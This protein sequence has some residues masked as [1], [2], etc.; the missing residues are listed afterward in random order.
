MS[1]LAIIAA[2]EALEDYASL[3]WVEDEAA[4]ERI[5]RF[6]RDDIRNEPEHP[7]D[8]AGIGDALVRRVVLPAEGIEHIRAILLG[9]LEDG[10]IVDPH[11]RRRC[12]PVCGL[13][14]IWPGQLDH[15]MLAVH[16]ALV[17]DDI[18]LDLAA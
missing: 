14:P 12:C 7:D 17:D 9:A 2:L 10:E 1:R 4:A 16:P 5:R 11:N 8:P 3:I 18:E 15:H 6:C 13:G